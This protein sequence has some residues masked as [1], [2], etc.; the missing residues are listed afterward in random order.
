M[1]RIA[2]LGVFIA[3]TLVVLALGIFIIGSKKYLFT[4][5]YKVKALFS[6]VSGLGT[7][8]DVRA[9]GVHIGTVERIELP[10]DPNGKVTVVMDLEKSTRDLV[11]RDSIASIG[12]E[13]LLGNEFVA[14][15]FG[16]T[17]SGELN[18]GDSIVGQPPLEMSALL[19]KASGLLDGSQK[20]IEN[21]TL[22]TAHLNSISAKIDSGQGTVGALVNDKALYNNLSQT[23]KGLNETVAHAQA[24]VTDFQENMEALKHNFFLSGYFKKRGYEDSSELTQDEIAKLPAVEPMKTFTFSAKEL[25]DGRESAKLKN[26]KTLQEGGEFLAGNQW[27]V[28]VIV[29]STGMEGDTAKDMTLTEARAAVVREYLVE[30]FGFDDSGLKTL[31]TGKQADAG[32]DGDWGTIKILVYPAG[33]ET[34]P[35]KQSAGTEA[36]AAPASK[37]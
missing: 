23:T 14:I 27:G 37:Q 10:H 9:G 35:G 7:G 28:A 6:N 16:S 8:A 20:A 30:H 2:R 5:T 25:F 4:P 13:G 17:G 24:G 3:G 36:L 21:A 33:T 29:A 32:G 18:D 26:Q 22:A 12:T 1:S 31:G 34:P 11:K 15:S 19:Q